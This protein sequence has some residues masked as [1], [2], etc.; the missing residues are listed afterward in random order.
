MDTRSLKLFLH[1]SE[2]LHFG[3]TS[4]AMHISPSA[5]TRIIQQLE[6]GLDTKLF[7]RDNRS[8]SLTR[9]G[10][11]FQEY[12]RES[13]QQWQSF[14][15]S[16]M[17]ETKELQGDI[18]IY[19]SV[20]ASYSFLY[21]ILSE[22]RTAHPK[23]GIRLHTGDPEHALSRVQNGEEDVAIASRTEKLPRTLDFKSIAKSKLLTI[24]PT[25]HSEKTPWHKAPLI[26]SEEGV[27]RKRVNHWFQQH[28][29]K[30]NIYA[31]VAGNEAIVSMV[32]L[33]YGVGVV[34]EIVLN[35]SPLADKVAIIEDQPSLDEIEVGLCTQKKR[36]QNP[37]IKALWDDVVINKG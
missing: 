29:L 32:S 24:A 7:V 21:N 9:S 31:Q 13:L 1:L 30:P 28:N 16:L 10:K 6:E 2:S 15:H 35:N 4:Q 11:L 19:C 8:V 36:L 22:F 17:E 25:H 23:I 20:T 27:I 5:L 18:S 37:L 34:P 33:G 3:R 14:Q 12:A 26:L